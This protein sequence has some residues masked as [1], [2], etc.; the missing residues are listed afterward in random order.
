MEESENRNFSAQLLSIV[1]KN[2]PEFE[3]NKEELAPL[4]ENIILNSP[5][6]K[7]ESNEMKELTRF[8]WKTEYFD[9]DPEVRIKFLDKAIKT[10]N[11]ALVKEL[12]TLGIDLDY[13]SKEYDRSALL[14]A[15][16]T[17]NI[18]MVK[19]LID[20]GASINKSNNNDESPLFWAVRTRNIELVEALLSYE[21]IDIGTRP[22]IM[23]QS[24]SKYNETHRIIAE[25]LKSHAKSNPSQ[26]E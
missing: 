2:L 18:K 20:N 15:C 12:A 23:S 7:R 26:S 21:D 17:E 3:K 1:S 16:A 9:E 11:Y 24:Y 5:A 13:F 8:L 19:L 6:F 4:I 14:L 25:M 22:L 10:M